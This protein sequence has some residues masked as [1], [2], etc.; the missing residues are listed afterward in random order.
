MILEDP[1]L[2]FGQWLLG[3]LPS[4]LGVLLAL[5][6]AGLFLGFLMAALRHGPVSAVKRTRRGI[7]EGFHDLRQMSLRR[8]TAM[9]RLAFQE[10]LRSK[11]LVAFALFVIML[12]FAGWFL[13]VESD[14]PERL[15]LSFVLQSAN[16]LVLVLAM[17][18]SSFSLPND[19]KN[20][21]I[22]TVV[23]K[24]VR[25]WE[26]V[27]GRIC[28]FVAIGSLMIFLMWI[29]SYIFVVTGLRHHHDVD[30]ASLTPLA[31]GSSNTQGVQGRT[32]FNS[33]HR[34]NFNWD[35]NAGLSSFERSAAPVSSR[36]ADASSTEDLSPF[37]LQAQRIASVRAQYTHDDSW[38]GGV[39]Y[40]HSLDDR[41]FRV[42]VRLGA[43]MEVDWQ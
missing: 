30:V 1:V 2:P 17:F 39:D 27:L 26:I 6:L 21:T 43:F 38:Y 25:A 7:A 31:S 14:S 34:H 5:V 11:V 37:V 18:L 28:G 40:E 32:T 23:T 16:Y 10:S 20:R 35:A 24:P 8:V 12:L 33:R 4:F 42:L 36:R 41:E 29:S 15:Y 9:A 3:N 19:M 22:Y 13:D